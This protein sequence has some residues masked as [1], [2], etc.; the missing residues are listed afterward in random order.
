MTWWRRNRWALLALPFVLALVAVSGASRLVNF[1]WPS[2]LREPVVAS[3]DEPVAFTA[4]TWDDAGEETSIDLTVSVGPTTQT[5]DF[6]DGDGMLQTVPYV[7]GTTVWQTEVTFT[8]PPEQD[9][10]LCYAEVVDT[11]GRTTTYATSA[12]GATGL[13][14][15]P[16]APLF[17]L[18]QEGPRDESWT[19]PVLVRLTSDVQPAELRIWWQPPDYV[20]VPLEVAPED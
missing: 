1:W 4:Q 14:L 3:V 20:S 6:T 13:P 7:E 15:S 16:C 12:L 9:P 18:S 19:V 11:Q 5:Q 2:Q 8:A 17:S 10:T